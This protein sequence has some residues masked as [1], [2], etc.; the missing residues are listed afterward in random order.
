MLSNAVMFHYSE[1][2]HVAMHFCGMEIS[3]NQQYDLCVYHVHTEVIANSFHDT[4]CYHAEWIGQLY[5]LNAIYI[6]ENELMQ[7]NQLHDM[8]ACVSLT[9]IA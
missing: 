8:P 2:L 6:L 3:L 1:Y 9:C 4:K 7:R 5:L